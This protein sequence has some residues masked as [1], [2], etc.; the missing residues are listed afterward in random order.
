MD[1]IILYMLLFILH[2][3]VIIG[4]SCYINAILQCFFHIHVLRRF[5]KANNKNDDEWA[6]TFAAAYNRLSDCVCSDKSDNSEELDKLVDMVF[7]RSTF[8]RGLQ[9]DAHGK[10]YLHLVSST[11]LSF[12][13]ICLVLSNNL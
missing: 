3:N 13:L 2:V 10:L 4:N 12:I 1:V 11:C 7:E 6:L 9:E 5:D 8:T